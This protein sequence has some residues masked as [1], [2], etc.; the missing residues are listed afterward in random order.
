MLIYSHST[1]EILTATIRSVS[2]VKNS[3]Y[4]GLVGSTF[5]NDVM[6][7]DGDNLHIPD[8][9]DKLNKEIAIAIAFNSMQDC[10]GAKQF[11]RIFLLNA[12]T[13]DVATI[14]YYKDRISNGPF[15][16]CV[17]EYS[18]AAF[19]TASFGISSNG[20]SS[21]SS[22]GSSPRDA[23]FLNTLKTALLDCLNAPCN[24]FKP[25]GTYGFLGSNT[26]GATGG[27]N[28]SPEIPDLLTFNKIPQA[29]QT[30][31]ATLS[32]M[33]KLTEA[34][35]KNVFKPIKERQQAEDA[36]IAGAQ[37]KQPAPTTTSIGLKNILPDNI[38][39]GIQKLLAATKIQNVL[40][41]NLGDCFR[42]QDYQRKYNP[43]TYTDSGG[44]NSE[45]VGPRSATSIVEKTVV[46]NKEDL[47]PP[48]PE[49]LATEVQQALIGNAPTN[50]FYNPY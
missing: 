49:K 31:G 18:Q 36:I 15:A 33:G 48:Q 11:V 35:I 32:V 44:S 39:Q 23:S 21:S 25:G 40:S 5:P 24:Y 26:P 46:P 8:E 22:F 13:L 38:T 29:F 34:K 3:E 20:L 45:S 1:P 28:S 6:A 37:A 27:V 2:D 30:A 16:D 41:V 10:E 7:L 9:P 12:P 43:Y 50:G 42:I 19:E 17:Q 14:L 47:I 4:C